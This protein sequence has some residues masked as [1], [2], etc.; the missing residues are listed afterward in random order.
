MTDDREL[1]ELAARAAGLKIDKSSTNGGG[2]GNTGF[3]CMGN[4][5]L[6]WH[7][8]KRWNPLTDDGDNARLEAALQID[9]TWH[10]KGVVCGDVYEFFG[11]HDNDKQKTRRYASVKA[12]A[13]IGRAL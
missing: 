13:E 7:N 5:V 1:L 3:D 12:A 6:D 4:A 8:N 10:K 9:T 11:D 2:I